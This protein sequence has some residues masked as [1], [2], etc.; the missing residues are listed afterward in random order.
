MRR[1][2]QR[3]R[4]FVR[5]RIALIVGPHEP[6]LCFGIVDF[7]QDVGSLLI[8][9]RKSF[10]RP[11]PAQSVG[12]LEDCGPFRSKGSETVLSCLS[13]VGINCVGLE[14]HER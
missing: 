7:E 2:P 11:P 6:P 10:G 8:G 5:A 1:T 14:V 3:R 9:I 4:Q 13:Q 12:S